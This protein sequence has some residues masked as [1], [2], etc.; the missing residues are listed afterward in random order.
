MSLGS[1]LYA[2]ET[3][4]ATKG[5]KWLKVAVKAASNAR[6]VGADQGRQINMGQMEDPKLTKVQIC[7]E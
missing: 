2:V 3:L 5:V 7:K 4:D 1:M 6:A